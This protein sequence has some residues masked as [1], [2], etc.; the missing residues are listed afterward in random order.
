MREVRKM[1]D[2]CNRSPCH[3]RCPN[4]K[5]NTTGIS[6]AICG[7][8]ILNGETYL[9]NGRGEYIHEDCAAEPIWIAE[10]LGCYVET[11]DKEVES[12]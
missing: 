2:I 12:Y 10:W 11:M 7:Y 4:H 5:D 1:C 8:P 3:P 6:C 9:A